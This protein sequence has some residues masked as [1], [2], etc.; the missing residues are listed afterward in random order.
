MRINQFTLF[1]VLMLLGFNLSSYN[2]S[3]SLNKN[4]VSVNTSL[5]KSAKE[6]NSKNYFNEDLLKFQDLPL[7]TMNEVFEMDFSL[8][9]VVHEGFKFCCLIWFAH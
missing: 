6:F 5:L 7:S 2:R 9:L 4:K 8:N 3:E 1:Y